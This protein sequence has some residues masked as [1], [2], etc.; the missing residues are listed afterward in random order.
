VSSLSSLIDFV[1]SDLAKLLRFAAVSA[2]TVPLGS[3]LFWFF[4]DVAELQPVV[5]NVV[6]VTLST[7]PN[8]IL[9]RR[10]VWNKR[11]T[12]SVGREIAPF[13]AMAFL[14]FLLSSLLVA[15]ADQFTDSTLVFLAANFIAFGIVW[16]FKFFVLEKYLFGNTPLEVSP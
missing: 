1:K 14:G 11:G 13:W 4:L 12:N 8:Y 6:A 3:T 10:W 15:I 9:N 16:I 2:I 5:A 7:I